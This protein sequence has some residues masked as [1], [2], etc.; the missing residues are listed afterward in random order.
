MCSGNGTNFEN[1]V[2]SCPEIEVVMM[3]YNKKDCGAAKKANKLGIPSCHIKSKDEDFIIRY[4]KALEVDYIVLA[5]W[6]RILSSKFIH[7]FPDKIINIHPSLLPKYKGLDSIQRALNN[8][9]EVTGC[10]VHMVTEELDSGKILMQE[11]VSI[12]PYDTLKTLTTAVHQAEHR[13]FPK[14]LRNLNING[15]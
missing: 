12:H 5:G 6:M 3:V 4:F 14:V 7:A 1:I 2:T 15:E 11:K 8:R 13:I 9:D 10:T